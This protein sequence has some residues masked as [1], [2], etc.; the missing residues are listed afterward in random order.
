MF[1]LAAREGE[2]GNSSGNF[3]SAMCTKGWRPEKRERKTQKRSPCGED[4]CTRGDR[5]RWAAEADE[6]K[7]ML[8]YAQ[9]GGERGDSRGLGG[10]ADVLRNLTVRQQ[11]DAP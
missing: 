4:D 7:K 2:G 6:A 9:G 10:L 5:G 8:T 1:Q 11:R 3:G